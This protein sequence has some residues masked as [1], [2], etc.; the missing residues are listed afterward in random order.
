MEKPTEPQTRRRRT[1]RWF[2]VYAFVPVNVRV[3][4]L[5]QKG[6]ARLALR[7]LNRTT[8]LALSSDDTAPYQ[9]A[10]IDSGS[11]AVLDH[12]AH[13]QT[14]SLDDE[15]VTFANEAAE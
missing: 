14:V 3:V 11:P 6:A 4:A 12:E 1:R 8:P 9:G 5:T 15:S 7:V 13:T 10:Y 2:M